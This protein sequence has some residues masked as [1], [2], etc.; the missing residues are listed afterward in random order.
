MTFSE[1]FVI[2]PVENTEFVFSPKQTGHDFILTREVKMKNGK[3][4]LSL[5]LAA[6][7]IFA[8][9]SQGTENSAEEKQS[10]AEQGDTIDEAA[11]AE[12]TEYNPFDALPAVDYGG[13]NFNFLNRE[14]CENEQWTEEL[15]GEAF[16][17]AVFER[18]LAVEE[19]F[20][21]KINSIPIAGDWGARDSFLA[22]VKK[23]VA[24][25]DGA[26]DLINGY[27]ATIGDGFAD[28]LY[29][30]LLDVPNLNLESEWWSALMRESLTVNGKLFAM[31]GDIAVNLW[32]SMQVIL[33]NKVLIN[34]YG[35]TSPYENVDDG[36]WTFDL[37][38]SLVEGS[39]I[40]MDGDGKWTTADRYGALYWDSLA[41]DNFHNAFGIQ[42]T[43]HESDGSVTLDL[44]NETV[45]DA[46]TKIYN[47]AFNNTGLL[48]DVSLGDNQ[49]TT[50]VNM[51]QTDLGLFL[52]CV[53]AD[54]ETL[55]DMESDFGIIPIPKANEQQSSYYT[56]SRDG[57]SM[58][59]IPIDVP[60]AD[61][62]GM[63][64]EALAIEG[65]LKVVPVYYDTVL[66][67]KMARDEESGRMLDILRNGIVLD[68]AAE[69]AM[70]MNGCGYIIRQCIQQQKEIA[71]YYAS[72]GKAFT[73]MFERFIKAYD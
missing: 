17:D 7:L 58:F 46:A 16:N 64:T 10:S 8:S 72:N 36:T 69:Y 2:M 52:G 65:K 18:N 27:A 56:T 13:R 66:K 50:S 35:Y 40:D 43:T 11:D 12:E 5:L 54:A 26:Y 9:C 39:E 59:V 34:D 61:F 29:L 25:G 62:A 73:K 37:Y 63:I 22:A 60:D 21:V 15:N 44:Y 51:F 3:S 70:Q 14:D 71:S 24:A 47:L 30:N 31:T 20:S 53:L 38:S 42:F 32:K 41:F 57:R 1:A 6:L 33:F 55:R 45:V 28:G 67:R 4:L 48:Y 68:F 19:K 23:A 49:H